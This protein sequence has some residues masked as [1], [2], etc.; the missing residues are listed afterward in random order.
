MELGGGGGSP[1]KIR[2]KESIESLTAVTDPLDRVI[3]NSS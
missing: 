2:C 3:T 1:I